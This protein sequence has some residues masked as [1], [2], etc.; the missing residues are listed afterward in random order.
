MNEIRRYLESAAFILVWMLAG[1]VFHLDANVYLL[2]GVPLV[3]L[4]QLVVGRQGI[5]RLW[6]RY[7][8]NFRLDLPGV[9]IAVALMV[10]P[11]RF[12]IVEALPTR[13]WPIILWVVCCL[14]GAVFA[15]FALRNQSWLAARQALP[16]FAM[17]IWCGC[18]TMVAAALANTCCRR[19][20]GSRRAP[21]YLLAPRWN[22]GNAC[23]RTCLHRRVS[24]RGAA[25]TVR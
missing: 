3:A 1:W 18:T 20:Y 15:A 25:L 22:V 7:A 9:A 17:V 12:L 8:L 11:S 4:F 21:V 24:R 6:A 13:Q 16:A 23:C 14:A 10:V 19:P 2:L 5:Q